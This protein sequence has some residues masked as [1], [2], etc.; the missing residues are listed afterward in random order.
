MHAARAPAKKKGFKGFFSRILRKRPSDAAE[1]EPLSPLQNQSLVSSAAAAGA[2]AG[3]SGV[4]APDAH[5]SPAHDP[6]VII[7]RAQLSTPVGGVSASSAPAAGETARRLA[8]YKDTVEVLRREIHAT[9][10]AL[11]TARDEAALARMEHTNDVNDRDT[12]I[13]DLRAI[14]KA[15]ERDIK[16]GEMRIENFEQLAAINSRVK[17]DLTRT[18][19]TTMMQ[20]RELKHVNKMLR[21]SVQELELV[22]QSLAKDLAA[23]HA[24]QPGHKDGAAGTG[25]QG[26]AAQDGAAPVA[27][28]ATEVPPT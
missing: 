9:S 17:M 28:F 15:K 26:G 10:T 13:R 6:A 27:A 1:H 16:D 14:V 20:N 12:V 24:P 22:N 18:L 23:C 5:L 21:K 7:S 8:R 19:D 3:A 4:A 11:S 2:F 25:G